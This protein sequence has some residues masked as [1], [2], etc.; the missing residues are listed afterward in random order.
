MDGKRK[1]DWDNVF[2]VVVFVI[3]LLLAGYFWLAGQ[4]TRANTIMLG[5]LI[6]AVLRASR[7]HGHSKGRR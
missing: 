6:L 5:L 4:A 1:I 3:A 7:G 2:L